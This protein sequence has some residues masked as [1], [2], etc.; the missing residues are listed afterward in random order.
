[1][2]IESFN[3]RIDNYTPGV[4]VAKEMDTT[5]L[6]FKCFISMSISKLDKYWIARE[7]IS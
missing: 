2:N 7:F 1:M 4:V 3:F 5:I 6:A